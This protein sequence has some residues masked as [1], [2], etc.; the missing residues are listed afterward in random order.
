MEVPV[1]CALSHTL[2]ILLHY[3]HHHHNYYY[4]SHLQDDIYSGVL[5]FHYSNG[6]EFVSDHL[7]VHTTSTV[8]EL[9]PELITRFLPHQYQLDA[10]DG[11]QPSSITLVQGQSE[12]VCACMCYDRYIF[13]G[14]FVDVCSPLKIHVYLHIVAVTA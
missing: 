13:L 10:V 2:W 12:Y 4:L 14:T 9:L 11:N 3:H 1:Y 6:L 8:T 5:K 7:P